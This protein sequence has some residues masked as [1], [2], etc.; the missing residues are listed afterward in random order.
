MDSKRTCS[1]TMFAFL[2]CFK[3][4]ESKGLCQFAEM[5]PPKGSES[6]FQRKKTKTETGDD[7]TKCP[8]NMVYGNCS[9]QTSCEDPNGKTNCGVSCKESKTCT[10]VDG[11]LKR[12]NQC[13][14][15]NECGCYVGDIDSV[16]PNNGTYVSSDCS[17]LCTCTNNNLSCKFDYQCSPNASCRIKDSIRQCF[18]NKGFEGDGETC[19]ALYTDCY[20]AYQAG[21]RDDGVYTIVPLGWPGTPIN[22]SCDMSN[23][24]GGWTI[25]QRRV[26][27]ITSFTRNW[28]SYKHG[29]GS[30]D[31]GKDFWLGNE[32]IFFL[33]N[34]KNCKLR[35]DIM[36]SKGT[37]YYAEYSLFRIDDVTTK[38]KIAYVGHHSGD[39]DNG[40]KD[41]N[42]TVFSTSD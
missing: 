33:T 11:F 23:A 35:I 5:F 22:V 25:F 16:V 41:L 39:T 20:D 15:A 18:C 17:M 29:F 26:D 14:R 2:L 12:G 10:C 30:L 9:C 7:I 34:Q 37:P 8:K 36:D 24:G 40:M 19:N 31:E 21:A 6:C 13:I 3:L 4:G 42:G 28:D 32:Q 38:Y 1:F 27:G